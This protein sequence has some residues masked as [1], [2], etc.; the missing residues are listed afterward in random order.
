[1]ADFEDSTSPTWSNIMNGQQK[2]KRRGKQ[3]IS[4]ENL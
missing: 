2:P 4:L 3:T 1:M